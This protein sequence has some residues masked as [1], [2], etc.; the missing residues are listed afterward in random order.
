M[1][2][3]VSLQVHARSHLH[4][5]IHCSATKGRIQPE[6]I[7]NSECITDQRNKIF[8][9]LIIDITVTLCGCNPVAFELLRSKSRHFACQHN[10]P[11]LT[12]LHQRTRFSALISRRINITLLLVLFK[13]PGYYDKHRMF[14]LRL[15]VI[16]STVTL[17]T[18]STGTYMVYLHPCHTELSQN[19]IFL[20]LLYF[21]HT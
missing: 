13:L 5:C 1:L 8:K 4:I 12:E 17:I 9:H 15:P 14:F 11:N 21:Q 18:S 6:V 2:T 10:H 19:Y 3:T 7:M 16:A 20:N